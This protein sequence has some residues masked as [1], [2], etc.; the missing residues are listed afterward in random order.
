M[1][2][3]KL[4]KIHAE[5]M[6]LF[7]ESYL[8]TIDERT[9]SLQDRRFYVVSGAQWEGQLAELYE[10]RA[11]FEV[12]KALAAVTRITNEYRNNRITVDFIGRGESDDELAEML[13]G[14]YR[15]DEQDS[16]AEEAY[17]NAFEE[18]LGGGIGAW[19]LRAEYE[20]DEDEDDY[21]Q[22]IKI[23]PIYDADMSVFF[24]SDAM[25][26]DKSD[27]KW[28]IV[29]SR[30]SRR[31]FEEE[32][33]EEPVS[34]QSE[35]SGYDWAAPDHITIAEYYKIE[36][37]KENSYTYKN[38][39]GKTEK[40]S[41]A[42]FEDDP[43]LKDTLLATGSTFIGK[44][45]V[46]RKRVRK[47]LLSG[48]RVLEDCGYIAGK[49]I[50]I[51]IVYGRR[52]M[53]EGIERF[54]GHVRAVKDAQRLKN[55][56]LSKLGEISAVSSAEKPIF[57]P[58]QVEGFEQM[59]ADESVVDYSHMLV[60]AI[61]DSA[62]NKLP[63]GPLEYTRPPQI[64]PA[65]AALLQI[66]E[67]DMSEIL[68]NQQAGEQVVSNISGKA[69]E[70]IQN[71]LDMQ[72]FIYRSNFAKGMR[73][74]GE[75][76][77]GMAKE[78]Y[79]DSA[80][81]KAKVVDK[82]GIARIVELMTPD[83]DKE[84]GAVIMKNDVSASKFDVIVDTGPA[85]SSRRA[86]T[87]RAAT[88]IMGMTQ[89]QETVQVLSAFALMNMEG[90]GTADMRAYARKK[91]LRLGVVKPTPEEMEEMAREADANSQP[92]ANAAYMEAAAQEALSAAQRNESTTAL[93]LAK[94]DETKAKTIK[95]LSDV[96]AS[97]QEQALALLEA[98]QQAAP[99]QQQPEQNFVV[100]DP[101]A[102]VQPV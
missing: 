81:R 50:P 55:M 48:T 29:L 93:N 99:E 21:N 75:V 74:C 39:L 25:R 92:D 61:E 10:K 70:L 94:A 101:S 12:N 83:I 46:S 60:N 19:R 72:S 80:R 8:A 43:E 69:V 11:K 53:I 33:D 79:T 16:V 26:Q 57:L 64:P 52:W 62:G 3:S 98:Y 77:L 17:D 34:W 23:E 22:R 30:M 27:A 47:Y 20:D 41:D 71:K 45:R 63:Q 18:A 6:E 35:K 44:K 56:Q 32:Y 84:S 31:A 28:C 90:E 102:P 78:L 89:D 13:D 73:R 42:D 7:D 2:D 51:I 4:D 15:A 37:V 54:M 67:Q 97:E 96:S 66:T 85:V 87:V 58:E 95:T 9:Q 65:L 1:T 38:A 100:I 68:G 59:W 24:P 36:E 86:A 40:Y 82:E 76:W 91:L 88:G 14:L 5:A 49:C